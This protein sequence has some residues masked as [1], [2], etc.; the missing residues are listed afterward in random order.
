VTPA[1]PPNA[2]ALHDEARGLEPL[3]EGRLGLLGP[4][5]EDAAGRKRGARPGQRVPS[6]VRIITEPP[7]RP[8]EE[9]EGNGVEGPRGE[10]DHAGH[11]ANLERD[12]RVP[13]GASGDCPQRPAAPVDH[14]PVELDH[15]HA[16]AGRQGL[17]GRAQREAHA[18]PADQHAG[19]A[20]P[21]EVRARELTQG[22]LRAVGN[23]RHEH[24]PVAGDEEVAL[25]PAPQLEHTVRGLLV[26]ERL[27]AARQ[28]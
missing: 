21:R 19:R 25:A 17:E 1:A 18:E 28:A 24:A 9:I 20:A 22:R 14:D 11:V 16:R 4:N 5:R 2:P 12:A 13:G 27:P 3:L 8:L 15:H 10:R 23:A 7:A 6:E 26:G